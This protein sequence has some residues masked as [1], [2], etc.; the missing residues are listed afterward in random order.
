MKRKRG[1]I[2]KILFVVLLVASAVIL[3]VHPRVGPNRLH[4][5]YGIAFAI[6]PVQ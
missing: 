4:A 3:N 5:Q 1:L 2:F 6:R